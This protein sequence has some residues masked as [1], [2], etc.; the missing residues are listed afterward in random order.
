MALRDK[1]AVVGIGDRVE[2]WF[3]RVSDTD[4][5]PRATGVVVGGRPVSWG[6][7]ADD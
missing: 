6:L 2:I 7:G 5:M 1:A 4:A 3:D